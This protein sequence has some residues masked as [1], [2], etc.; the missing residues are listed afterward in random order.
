MRHPLPVGTR[1]ISIHGEED[2]NGLAAPGAI[3]RIEMSMHRAG[4][5]YLIRAADA[6]IENP[7]NVREYDEAKAD[8][9]GAIAKDAGG[10]GA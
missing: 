6:A 9:Q 1:I 5:H 4:R 8:A 3:G 2:G 7:E 10:V